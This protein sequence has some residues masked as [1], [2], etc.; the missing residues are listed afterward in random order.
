MKAQVWID[1][2]IVSAVF[3]VLFHVVKNAFIFENVY[4]QVILTGFLGH[5]FMEAVRLNEYYCE[6]NHKK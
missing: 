4:I 2:S 6:T 5:L 3:L 1:A